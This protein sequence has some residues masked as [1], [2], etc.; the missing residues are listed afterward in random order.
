MPDL[1]D[2]SGELPTPVLLRMAY[3][4]LSEHIFQR[5]VAAG[6]TDQ[7]PAHGNAMES[8]ALEDGLRL[9]DL[10]RRAA[11]TPQ[12]MGELVDDLVAKG[13]LERRED[14]QDRR[15]KR[16]YLTPKGQAMAETGRI[17]T[18][19]IEEQVREALG[20]RPYQQLRR[21]LMRITA[22]L[23]TVRPASGPQPADS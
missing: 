4:L 13:Y 5:I 11:M 22:G 8:L 23:P 6:Y 21:S 14:P 15:A 12:A 1:P 3:Y 20:S 17:A 10:A 9:T 2:L 18:Q 19:A 16:I 7:R